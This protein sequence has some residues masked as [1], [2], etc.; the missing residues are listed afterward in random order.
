MIIK[1]SKK[2]AKMLTEKRRGMTAEEFE[3]RILS[4]GNRCPIGNHECVGRGLGRQAPARDHCHITGKNRA[5]L[6]SEH[7]RALGMFHDSPEELQ[8]ALDYLREWTEKHAIS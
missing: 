6:C 1:H 5:I 7:N 3:A 8:A 2:A 4:Q